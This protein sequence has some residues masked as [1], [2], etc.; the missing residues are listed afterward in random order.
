MDSPVGV[1]LLLLTGET[2]EWQFSNGLPAKK[3]Q[4]S[5]SSVQSRYIIA[6]PATALTSSIQNC[7]PGPKDLLSENSLD[8][9]LEVVGV[10]ASEVGGVTPLFR[11][12]LLLWLLGVEGGDVMSFST[13]LR[14]MLFHV[15]ESRNLVLIKVDNFDSSWL[16]KRKTKVK[17]ICFGAKKWVFFLSSCVMRLSRGRWKTY[18]NTSFP[19]VLYTLK[20][21]LR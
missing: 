15:L 9:A 21:V 1:K 7:L 2:G 19:R 17:T 18:A 13:D 12:L 11:L 5:H 4:M 14:L 8:R 10:A 6:L 20:S 16:L 3:C